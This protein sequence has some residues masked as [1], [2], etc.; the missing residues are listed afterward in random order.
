MQL[1]C[2]KCGRTKGDVN[3]YT[4]PNGSKCEMCK[5]CLTMYI[6]AWE[7]DTYIFLF[8]K[9]D[10]PYI[11]HEWTSLRDKEFKNKLDKAKI[12]GSKDPNKDAL[13]MFKHGTIFGKY[14]GKMKLNQYNKYRWAD[15]ERLQ[16]EFEEKNR[17][18][19]ENQKKFAEDIK[20]QYERGEISESEYMTFHILEAP[21]PSFETEEGQ[22]IPRE[23]D[24]NGA[25]PY[26][27]ANDNPFE[28]IDIPD[29]GMDLTDED[30]VYLAMKW[31]RLYTAAD[32]IYLDN[33]YDDFKEAFGIQDGDAGR[34]DTLV[35][36]CKLSLKMNQALDSGD[37]D[38]YSKM[39]RA[40][41]TLMKSAKFTEAQ[42]KEERAGEF[43]SIG[44]MVLLCE[45][46]KSAIDRPSFDYDLD[47]VDKVIRELK[48]YNRSLIM[49]D[50]AVF[51]QIE[52]YI[53]KREILAEQQAAEAEALA[54]GDEF[55]SVTDQ[56]LQDYRDSIDEQLE[57]DND[58][59]S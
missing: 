24:V 6:N 33:K 35:Q 59:L 42:N 11:E 32:W 23:V 58:E 30:K 21:A 29:P 56:D 26:F 14:L 12:A 3:F 45:K 4:Y 55:V 15:T 36:V 57:E 39:A 1:F 49:S 52:E 2:P 16:A 22:Y 37:I 25:D 50:T 20:G 43:D 5:D 40:Y 28:K 46:N 8:P 18:N 27:P 48:E 10:I 41:D 9:F 51:K 17:L 44:E 34:L 13:A 38:G 53:K 31:G 54:N 19:L 47:I 7:K